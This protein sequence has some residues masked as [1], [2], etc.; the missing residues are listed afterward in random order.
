MNTPQSQVDDLTKIKGIGRSRQ[1][2][3]SQ[4]LAVRTYEQLAQ[5]SADEVEGALRAAG[6]LPARSE[7]ENWLTHCC[8]ERPMPLIFVR[9]ST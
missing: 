4:A 5:L 1:Q 8:L 9:S 7:I 6:K 3:F 2:W